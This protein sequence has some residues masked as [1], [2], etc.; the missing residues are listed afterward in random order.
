MLTTEAIREA[1]H[2]M[3]DTAD[4]AI[5]MYMLSAELAVKSGNTTHPRYSKED[6]ESFRKEHDAYMRNEG[7][8]YTSEEFREIIN[9][10]TGHQKSGNAA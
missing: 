9:Q 6:L 3:A 7:I 4:E 2:R 10:K 5:L 8:T 1:V